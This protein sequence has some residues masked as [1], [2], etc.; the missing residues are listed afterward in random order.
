MERYK[1]IITNKTINLDT[2]EET[3]TTTEK[4]YINKNWYELT[5]EQKEKAIE[6]NFDNLYRF[7]QE[8]LYNDWVYGLDYLKEEFKSITFDN[9]YLDGN[10]QGSWIDKIV[11][12]KLHFDSLTVYNECLEVEDVDLHICKYIKEIEEQD[13]YIYDY[14]INT[15]KLERI[16][17][18]KKYKTWINKIIKEVNLWI[19]KVNELASYMIKNEYNTPTDLNNEEEANYINCYFENDVFTYELIKDEKGQYKE[20]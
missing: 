11:N 15:N 1:E 8:E 3:I 6:N 7:Y 10:S 4:C 18:T 20:V 5:E 16:K 14:Y 17:K 19:D 2:K 12:F 9:I 13:V